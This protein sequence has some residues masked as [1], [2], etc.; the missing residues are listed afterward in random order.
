M[1]R[2][3]PRKQ[4]PGRR[5]AVIYARVSSKEQE[6]EGF[7]IPAQL[8]L[9]QGY[10]AERELLVSREFVDIETAKAAGRIAFGEM[11]T[12][13][14]KV[15]NCRILLVEK[16]DRLYRNLRD[17]VT[18]DE[19]DGLEIHLVKEGSVISHESR[20]S[21]RF[22]HGI[23]VLMARQ[24]VENLSEETR[25]GMLEKVSQGIWPSQAPL[26]YRNVVGP[27][28]KKIIE[29]DPEQA[30]PVRKLFRMYSSGIYSLFDL[31]RLARE[32]GLS[33]RKSGG[34]L[35]RSVVHHMLTSPVYY[36]EIVWKGQHY[37]G[38]HE[39]LVTRELWDQVQGILA[40]HGQHRR[41]KTKSN[42]AFLGLVSC[43]GCG[44]M[45]TGEVKKGIFAYYHC[46]N[47]QE[48][49][50]REP[51]T[52]EEALERELAKVLD[53]VALGGP[54]LDWMRKALRESHADERQAHAEAL[55][56][57]QRETSRLQG[58]LEM[59]YLDRLDG[60]IPLEMYER[61]AGRWRE[62]Q[63]RAQLQLDRHRTAN[64]TYIDEGIRL[65]ELASRARELFEQQP[66]QEKRRLLDHLVSNCVWRH[67]EIHAE[68]KTPF[69]LIASAN[70]VA[71]KA[72]KAEGGGPNDL[73]EIWLPLLHN[74]RNIC[75][76]PTPAA[77]AALEAVLLL[78][79]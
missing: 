58:R 63:D 10:A 36:G 43:G 73:S 14:R 44:R 2:K 9:L 18:L 33:Y 21:E 22:V 66:A 26:G 4:E 17:W 60:R 31:T 16:T 39:P 24:Y 3:P 28:G 25:K 72:R 19:I 13:L 40:R 11:L 30:E 59:L 70:A 41:C 55:Q 65:L 57:L 74:Y 56:R 54:V 37:R 42:L 47:R 29:P 61:L 35:P 46:G 34:T 51:F 78:A 8:K 49:G 6:R 38:V 1:G 76:L 15:P 79:G 27:R 52:R 75:L 62:E 32:A 12:H 67:G 23:K 77:R 69:D 64:R 48:T 71:G 53:Q 20:S 68:F 50:C 45:L 7:S 5:Q